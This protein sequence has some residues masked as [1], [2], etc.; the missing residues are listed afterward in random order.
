VTL[1]ALIALG[2]SGVTKSVVLS[3]S[4]RKYC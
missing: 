2:V 1:T 4:A 3:K